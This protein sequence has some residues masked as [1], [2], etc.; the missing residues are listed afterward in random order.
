LIGNNQI[1]NVTHN[2][3]HVTDAIRQ[4]DARYQYNYLSTNKIRRPGSD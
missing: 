2:K 1:V 4:L 3:G